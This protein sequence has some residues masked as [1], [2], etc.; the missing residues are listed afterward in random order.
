MYLD[1]IQD[2]THFVDL[3]IHVLIE[4]MKQRDNEFIYNILICDRTSSPSLLFFPELCLFLPMYVSK[5]FKIE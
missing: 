3:L 1:P 4:T 2:S 5:L